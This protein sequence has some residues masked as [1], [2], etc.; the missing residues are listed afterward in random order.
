MLAPADVDSGL[1]C[2]C[3]C[4]GC[5]ATLVAKKGAKVSWH[6]AHHIATG[7][8]SC[9]ES[10]IHA[11]A[12]QILLD[13][14]YLRTPMVAVSAERRLK[15]G[16][17][18]A[19]SI[20][21]SSDRVIRFDYS[22]SE[23]WEGAANVRPDVVGY[24][25]ER[26]ILVEMYFTHAVDRTKKK[27]LEA[28]GIPALE[29]N[30]SGLASDTDLETIRQRVLEDVFFKDWLF[31]PGEES[32]RVQLQEQVDAEADEIDRRHDAELE[33]TRREEAAKRERIVKACEEVAEANTRYRQ[34]PT[35]EK[36]RLVREAL[37]ISG[38]WPYFLNTSS[39][40]AP[41]ILE[42]AHIWQGA[43]FARFLR[44]KA[45]HRVFVESDVVVE[46]V[47]RRF[48]VGRNRKGLAAIAVRKFLGYLCTCGF[49][50]NAGSSGSAAYQVVF[51][52]LTSPPKRS[53]RW[54]D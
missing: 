37:G 53:P 14:N 13:A 46:W 10:A 6:F 19:K 52:Q 45:V 2:G 31:Y 12:K 18:H 32:T 15:T 11:A 33:L 54:I 43:V 25:G 30:L 20:I 8:E 49:L 17:R 5:G 48:G 24:R 4:V 44:G 35:A 22:R 27:K 38:A 3:T 50:E 21:L 36:E 28:L 42:P 26:R 34:L 39:V 47:A 40:E 16:R 1:A 9:V 41:S 51:D 23:V 29:V 7:S